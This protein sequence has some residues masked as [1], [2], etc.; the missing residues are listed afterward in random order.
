MYESEVNHSFLCTHMGSKLLQCHKNVSDDA[1]NLQKVMIITSTINI[2]QAYSNSIIIPTIKLI[3]L[4]SAEL[5][6]ET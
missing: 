1:L 4:M 3:K 2:K 6:S 5:A